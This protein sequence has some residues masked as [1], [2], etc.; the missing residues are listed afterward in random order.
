M[1]GSLS[2]G[3]QKSFLLQACG[4]LS[5]PPHYTDLY[6]IYTPLIITTPTHTHTHTYV[7]T[8]HRATARH[9]N[10][11]SDMVGHYQALPR[12]NTFGRGEWVAISV[13]L[14]HLRSLSLNCLQ[15]DLYDTLSQQPS[16]EYKLMA[17]DPYKELL[18]KE[19]LLDMYMY[20]HVFLT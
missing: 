14:S 3:V 18:G 12:D 10:E 20:S 9:L 4:E 19:W 1:F 16:T 5:P 15:L 17:D 13:V 6:K 8:P 7:N 2:P 11:V